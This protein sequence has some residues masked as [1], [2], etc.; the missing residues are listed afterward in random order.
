MGSGDPPGLQ[1]RR[2]A[3]LPVAGAFDS[4][5]LPPHFCLI[6]C[7]HDGKPV[8]RGCDCPKFLRYSGDVCLCGHSH[9]GRLHRFPTGVRSWAQAEEKRE[10]AQKRI[11]AGEAIALPAPDTQKTI[12]QAVA[13]FLLRKE[14][15]QLSNATLRKLRQQLGLF[16]QFLT[17]RSRFFPSEIT[18][19]D[20]I[21]FRASW[22]WKSGVTRQ[23]A[24]TNI[25]GFL[26]AA[27]P[28][29]EALVKALG[30]IKL[31]KA[32][33]ARLEPKP[34]SEQELKRLLAQVPKT[35]ASD[36]DK[37]S[38]MTALIHCQV[39][40]GLAIRDTI[41]LERENLSENHLGCWL[42]IKR[43][44][45][46]KPVR[47][48]IDRGLYDELLS[49]TNSNPRYVFWNGTSLPTSATGLWQEDLRQS[50]RA[51]G[52]Y[53]KGNLSHHFRDTTVGFWLGQVWTLDDIADAL[54]D[55]V[56]VVEK[57]YK[58]LASKRTEKRLAAL[59]TRSWTV[60]AQ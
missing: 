38:R 22:N 25:K 1:N 47:Q 36:S 40:T 14:G 31:S 26:R 20:V 13:S 23:K 12:A 57:H 48:K 17:A 34:Y 28:H 8:W 53:E 35:F 54:G 49:V 6:F 29:S 41:Q 18:P 33:T 46:N 11:D 56:A 52:L 37:I 10:E 16:E 44:K 50:M 32:D 58:D 45:T 9:K 2:A 43:Q 3:G 4:H 5:T 39:A 7:K 55:T 30:T 42:R 19:D 21:E 27:C 60:E 15:G 51:A 24:Q 59:P